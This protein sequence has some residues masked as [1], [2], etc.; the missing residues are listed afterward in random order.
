MTEPAGRR[1]TL[2]PGGQLRQQRYFD[3]LELPCDDIGEIDEPLHGQVVVVGRCDL[4]VRNPP[5]RG[6]LG[7]SGQHG[8]PVPEPVRLE[9]QHPSQ[10]S[11][12]HDA[13]GASGC[14]G[15]VHHNSSSIS[16]T[17]AARASRYAVS[18][19]ASCGSRRASIATA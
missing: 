19:P 11:T 10:L 15:T 1:G 12:T 4:D 14:Y 3:V 17:A 6:V 13:D 16:R 18:R 7:P 5:A 8:H 9:G 2:R